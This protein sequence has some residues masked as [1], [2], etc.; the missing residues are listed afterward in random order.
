MIIESDSPLVEHLVNRLRD[1][2]CDAMTFRWILKEITKQ[3]L[4]ECAHSL[5]T[6]EKKIPTWQG[7]FVGNFVDESRITCVA[8]LRAALPMQEGVLETLGE[9]EGGFLAMKRDEETHESRLYYDRVPE[10]T[11]K[12]VVLVDPMVATGGSLYDA[13]ALLKERGPE[14]IVTLHVIGAKEGV[15]KISQAFPD[16]DIHIARIDPILNKDA[17]IVPGLGDAGD[18]AYNTPE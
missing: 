17:Y 4:A 2:H 12:T 10:L 15:E 9:A 11:G 16:V 6:V 5:P 13:L 3:L 1:A 7:N 14:K 8:I 18:R